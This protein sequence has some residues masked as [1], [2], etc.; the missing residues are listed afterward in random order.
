VGCLLEFQCDRGDHGLRRWTFHIV[1]ILPCRLSCSS[2]DI[3][4]CNAFS[5]S[6]LFSESGEANL[7]PVC[8]IAVG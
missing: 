6:D 7:S 2:T 4:L 8:T 1:R 3:N 5:R